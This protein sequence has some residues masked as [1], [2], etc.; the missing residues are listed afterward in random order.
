MG[1]PTRT[2]EILRGLNFLLL[3]PG[4][5]LS[6]LWIPIPL[7]PA[8]P[9]PRPCPSPPTASSHCAASGP[10]VSDLCGLPGPPR[11]LFLPPYSVPAPR[12]PR[13]G[14]PPLLPPGLPAAVRAALPGLPRPH[15]GQL[16]LGAQRALAPGLFRLPGAQLWGAGPWREGPMGAGLGVGAGLFRARPLGRRSFTLAGGA[17]G[18]GSLWGLV[19]QLQKGVIWFGGWR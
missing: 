12:F 9:P 19:I 16:H 8:L 2:S 5:G 6:H 7:S 4:P 11:T 10:P 14:G 18:C 13:A 17:R 1:P 3:S 15:S